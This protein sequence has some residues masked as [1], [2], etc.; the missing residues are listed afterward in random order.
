MRLSLVAA[1]AALLLSA[2]P[3]LSPGHT[4]SAQE[5]PELPATSNRPELGR[6]GQD[7]VVFESGEILVKFKPGTPGQTIADAHRQNGDREKET[8]RGID[9]KVVQ[10][11]A[12]QEKAHVAAYRRNPNVQFAELNAAYFALGTPNDPRVGEQWQYNN[13]GLNGGKVDADIDAFEAWEKATGITPSGAQVVVAILDTGIDQDH[14]DLKTKL[15]RNVNWTSSRTVD[16]KYGHGTHVAGSAAAVTNNATGVA[17]TCPNCVLH[18]VKVLGDDG[19]GATSWIANGIVDAADRGA[20]VI[21]MSF[22][23]YTVSETQNRALD[24]AASKGV[25]LVAAAGNDGKDWGLYPAA[26]D[27]PSTGVN[28]IAVAATDRTDLRASFSNYGRWVDVSAPGASILSTAPNH[29]NRLW[30]TTQTYATLNGTSMAAPHVAGLAGLIWSTG[31]CSTTACVNDRLTSTTDKIDQAI[32]I[33]DGIT[34]VQTKLY[35][36][37]LQGRI[38]ACRAVGGSC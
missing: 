16:D 5:S 4:V 24:Y 18:N 34:G 35:G 15:A 33:T 11:P 13:T 23:S 28:V 37:S 3:W 30:K 20:Q 10:V 12:G 1:V 19:S 29:A 21:N 6:P 2:Q 26:Y 38:N 7:P 36:G 8:L 32:T 31:T 17:G 27:N 14:P 25:V 9:V 22:G